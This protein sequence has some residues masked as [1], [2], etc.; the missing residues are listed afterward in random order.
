MRGE[1]IGRPSTR[2]NAT[3]QRVPHVIRYDSTRPHGTSNPRTEATDDVMHDV[4]HDVM[5]DAMH[6]TD[7]R[8]R[9]VHVPSTDVQT[10]EPTVLLS[11]VTGMPTAISAPTETRPTTIPVPHTAMQSHMHTDTT[12]H[13]Q[14]PTSSDHTQATV[15][16]TLP[17]H[18]PAHTPDTGTATLNT[19]LATLQAMQAQQAQQQLQLAELT[20]T[21][22]TTPAPLDPPTLTASIS[23]ASRVAHSNSH[24]PPLTQSTLSFSHTSTRQPARASAQEPRTQQT[25]DAP[26]QQ[27]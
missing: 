25:R 26:Q 15:T 3:T 5:D 17:M 16:A 27:S 21:Q 14:T 9:A 6:E 20:R 8:A 10:I 18:L 23:G 12:T 1:R 7:V 13:T 4:V 11:P 24:A 19:I 22:H 2:N